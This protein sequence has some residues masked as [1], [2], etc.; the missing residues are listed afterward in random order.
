MKITAAVVE[1]KGGPFLLQELE[2]ESPRPDEILVR[3]V[4]TGICHSDL[5]ARDQVTFPFPC[6]MVF[7]HEGA[8]VVEEVGANVSHLKAGDRVLLSRLTCG[9][10]Q[11]CRSGYSN[12]CGQQAVLNFSGGRADGST[13]LSR[14]GQPVA[15]HFFGQSSF[16]TYAVANQFNATLIPAEL[17]LTLAPAFACGVLTGAG[18]V[19]NGLRPEVGTS[20]AVFGCGSVGL[21]AVMAAKALGCTTIVAIDPIA[22]RLDLA[23]ELGATHAIDASAGPTDV[24][25]RQIAPAGVHFSVDATGVAAVVRSAVECLRRGGQCALMGVAPAGAEISLNPNRIAM[26]GVGIKGFPS[27]LAEPD[28]LVPRLIELH[29][30]GRFPVDRIVKRFPFAQI[31]EAAEEA[32]SGQAVKPI[33]IFN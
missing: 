23:R 3:M 5:A 4:A 33:L 20:I 2:L 22:S 11:D 26:A 28:V 25:I 19:L 17:D 31:R 7:G 12:Y 6:P 32:E 15:G 27:G 13:S 1:K 8:G 29:L 24:T 18:A 10:C 16:A 30:Q 21:A 9:R 14:Q